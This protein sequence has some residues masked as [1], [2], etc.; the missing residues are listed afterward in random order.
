MVTSIPGPGTQPATPVRKPAA[1]NNQSSGIVINITNPYVVNGS[2]S[3][4]EGTASPAPEAAAPTSVETPASS[5]AAP[6]TASKPVET[7]A[8]IAEPS[9]AKPVE[10]KTPAQQVQDAYLEALNAYNQAKIKRDNYINLASATKPAEAEP[11]LPESAPQPVINAPV[12]AVSE[13]PAQPVTPVFAQP[14]QYPALAPAAPQQQVAAYAPYQP[15]FNPGQAAPPAPTFQVLPEQQPAQ[16]TSFAQGG[17]APLFQQVIQQQ[18]ASSAQPTPTATPFTYAPQSFSTPAPQQQPDMMAALL[19]QQQQQ[20]WL[21]AQQ[22]QYQAMQQQTLMAQQAAAMQQYGQDPMLAAAAQQGMT[23]DMLAAMQQQAMMAQQQAALMGQDPSMSPQ[24]PVASGPPA[25]RPL[26]GAPIEVLNQMLAQPQSLNDKLTAIHEIGVSGQSNPDT[27]K[28]LAS[29][30]LTD[31]SK[32]QGEDKAYQNQVREEAAYALGSLPPSPET[33][34]AFEQVL[35]ARNESPEVKGA[36]VI[37]LRM[38]DQPAD[39]NIAKLLKT[40]EAKSQPES[41]RQQA[42]LAKQRVPL[43][44][45]G[46]ETL[47]P[48]PGAGNASEADQLAA[49]MA[50]MGPQ[51]GAN[52]SGQSFSATA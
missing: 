13:P 25:D 34:K 16:P 46:Q 19:Q 6:A 40:A 43:T 41:V 29:T 21:Q 12:F 2:A 7:S 49:L 8:K 23:P 50:M 5:V 44:A 18:P 26:M 47:P 38:F 48:Q 30:L 31:T 39:K 24:Q 17:Y 27:V 28:L 3:S 51:A 9:E 37:A 33:F 4:P 10:I 45:P 32:L 42:A 15:N 1:S 22:A 11:T 36:A 14:V 52:P 20:Q 35:K